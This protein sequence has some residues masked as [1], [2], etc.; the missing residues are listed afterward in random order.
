VGLEVVD[1]GKTRAYIG[2]VL[3]EETVR[4]IVPAG[5][6][7]LAMALAMGLLSTPAIAASEKPLAVVLTADHARLDNVSAAI[8]ADVF[9]GDSLVTDQGGSLRLTVG[10][11]QVYL[12]SASAATLVPHDSAVQA[13][14]AR[15]T[16][17]FSSSAAGQLEIETPLGVIRAADGKAVFGQ[18]IVVSPTRMRVSAY[19]GTLLV[20]DATGAEKA[21]AAGETYEANLETEPK[22]SD[23][24]PPKGV[25]GAGV[26]WKHVVDVAIPAVAAGVLACSLWP[27]S[28]SSMGCW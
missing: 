28:D 24:P 17:G 2:V 6:R 26:N 27:E 11:S 20:A 18:V 13:R 10:L 8:G 16:V 1:T 22:A 3:S 14:V 9:S 5:A 4:S 15:G 25:T 21:I 19:Q 23:N 12:L 7:S